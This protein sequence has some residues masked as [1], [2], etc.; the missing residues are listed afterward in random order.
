MLTGA[1]GGLEEGG[2]ERLDPAFGHGDFA[3]ELAAFFEPWII[4]HE[5]LEAGGGGAVT[6]GLEEFF[7]QVGDE[8]GGGD[9]AEAGEGLEELV[10]GGIGGLE[11]PLL[12][13]AVEGAETCL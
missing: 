13:L 11:G 6:A 5:G 1:E 2:A 3:L 4:A 9:G 7:G 10:A 8:F 12:D